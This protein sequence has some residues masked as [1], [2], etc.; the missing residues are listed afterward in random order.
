MAKAPSQGMFFR[1]DRVDIPCRAPARQGKIALPNEKIRHNPAFRQFS[2]MAL[3]TD[4]F[5]MKYFLSIISIALTGRKFEKLEQK[6]YIYGGN[7]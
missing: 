6:I 5:F 3:F 1:C 7:I 2:N 4:K